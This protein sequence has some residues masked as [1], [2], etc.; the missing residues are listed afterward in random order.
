MPALLNTATADQAVFWLEMERSISAA[1]T[2]PAA[3]AVR[4]GVQP[5]EPL[6]QDQRRASSQELGGLDPYLKE[7]V[8]PRYLMRSHGWTVA[9]P[10]G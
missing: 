4:V 7:G 5:R 9:N 10:A 3:P 1:V 6:S 2:P 8:W